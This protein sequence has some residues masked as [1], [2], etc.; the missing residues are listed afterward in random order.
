MYSL[1]SKIIT[2]LLSTECIRI[3]LRVVF[4][5]WANLYYDTMIIYK[6]SISYTWVSSLSH[7]ARRARYLASNHLLRLW[8]A[9]ASC[10]MY[11]K[12]LRKKIQMIITKCYWKQGKL[13]PSASTFIRKQVNINSEIIQWKNLGIFSHFSC[14]FINVSQKYKGQNE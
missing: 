14:V 9:L 12:W 6:C 11:N 10:D 7:E 1:S 13:V 3:L 5:N 8:D 4:E 2:H